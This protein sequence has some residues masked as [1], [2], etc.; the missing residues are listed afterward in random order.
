MRALII[1]R[2]LI[3]QKLITVRGEPRTHPWLLNAECH[4]CTYDLTM[5]LCIMHSGGGNTIYYCEPL[6]IPKILFYL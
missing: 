2:P 3:T 4:L 5:H 1:M 6:K